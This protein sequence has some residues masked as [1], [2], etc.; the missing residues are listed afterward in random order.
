MS[1]SNLQGLQQSVNQRQRQYLQVFND[2]LPQRLARTFENNFFTSIVLY[3][4]IL[5]LALL[6]SVFAKASDTDLA[7]EGKQV[8]AQAKQTFVEEKNELNRHFSTL[9]EQTK[10]EGSDKVAKAKL[11]AEEAMEKVQT[12]LAEAKKDLVR[13]EDE[14]MNIKASHAEQ[15]K[16]AKKAVEDST[17]H[18]SDLHY[19]IAE[20]E[21]KIHALESV[22]R[23]F[24]QELEH[25]KK[26]HEASKEG[27]HDAMQRLIESKKQQTSHS[28]ST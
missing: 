8:A 11:A 15:L 25:E 6:S 1:K 22:T 20:K 23:R 24:E 19:Q 12:Q 18:V 17:V 27:L 28:V 9:L 3:F 26:M 16:R 10:A 7:K 5:S 14:I 21:K 2:H 4:T 13:Y